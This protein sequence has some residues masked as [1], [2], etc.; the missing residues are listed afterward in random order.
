MMKENEMI[1]GI[2]AII[3][4]I[5]SDKEID[6]IILKKD[7]QSELSHELFEVLR[8]HPLI[9]VQRVPLERINKYTRKNHQGAI[10][11]I[12]STH[13]QR[14]EDLVQ[15]IFEEGKDPFFII[16][17]GVTDV[18]NFGAIARTCEC[19]G[20]DA[21]V[22]PFRGSVSVGADAIK[23]SAGALHTLPVC[24]EKNLVQTVKYLKASGV[25]VVAATEKGDKV[26]TDTNLTGPLAI[27]MGAED[28]GVSPE[29]IRLCDDLVKIPING[30]ISSLN[31]SV[32]AGVMIYESI[33]Q[34]QK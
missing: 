15:N 29:I 6:K 20:V 3:E 8:S 27:V 1:F 12:S 22:I 33:R 28:T 7:L 18:R 14:V 10:A 24:K 17:D 2:R 4:A 25:R 19:A 16:L 13:Y 31:V 30:K 9:Q 34:R 21:V 26:Y 5:E 11:F 32:A 23:T